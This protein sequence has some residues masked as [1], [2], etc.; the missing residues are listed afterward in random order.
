MLVWLNDTVAKDLDT[1]CIVSH[2]GDLNGIGTV[3]DDLGLSD[4]SRE[5]RGGNEGN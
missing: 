5:F 4:M 3:D 1:G 2:L